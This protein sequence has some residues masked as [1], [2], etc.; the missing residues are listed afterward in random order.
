MKTTRIPGES[1]VLDL[2]IKEL[3]GKV[4]KVGWF[5]KSEYPAE[6]GKPSIKV[7][8]VAAIQERGWPARN[9]PARPMFAPTIAAKQGEWRKKAEY[10]A[11]DI[12]KGLVTIEFVMYVLGEKVVEDVAHTI[13]TLWEPKLS[14]V[15]VRLRLE[16]KEDK[17]TRGLID[18]PLIDTG[19]MYDTLISIVEDG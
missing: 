19:L 2:A 1:A 12:L 10:G 7:A 11:K 16:R 13:D 8:T 15:T 18:K 3:A 17:K 5:E 9:I 6:E 14:E 4:A